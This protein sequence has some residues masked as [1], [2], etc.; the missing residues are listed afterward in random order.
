MKFCFHLEKS[1]K[2]TLSYFL[3]HTYYLSRENGKK[4]HEISKHEN[5]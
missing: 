4:K 5:Y 3:A 1:I 2:L